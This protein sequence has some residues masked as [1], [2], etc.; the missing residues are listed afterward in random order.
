MTK[1]V[2]TSFFSLFAMFTFPV[3]AAVNVEVKSL[4]NISGNGAMEACGTASDSLGTSPL[5]VTV[6]HDISYYSTLTDFQGNWCVLVKRWNFSG[7]IEVS[8][9][10]FQGTSSA[11]RIMALPVVATK[12]QE[13]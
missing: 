9:A 3:V 8:A 5:L 7:R 4:T 10:T 6:K 12:R 11:P 2:G 1:I 13:P